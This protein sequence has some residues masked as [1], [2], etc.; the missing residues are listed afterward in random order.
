MWRNFSLWQI[1][2][3]F[4]MWRNFSMWQSFPTFVMVRKFPLDNMSWGNF[5]TWL[6]FLHRQRLW[7]LLQIS[8]MGTTDPGYCLFALRYLSGYE[9]CHQV[10]SLALL[11]YKDGHRVVLALSV[12]IEL[13][14]SSARVAPVQRWANNSVFEYHSNTWGRILVFVFVFGWFFQAE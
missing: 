11:G 8:G 14:S 4:F 3:T 9:E 7:C 1:F 13:V 10:I 5:S 6:I 2:P 12:N